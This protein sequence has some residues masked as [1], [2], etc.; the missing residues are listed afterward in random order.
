MSAPNPS[1]QTITL[2]RWPNE[3]QSPD[4]SGP[5]GHPVRTRLDDRSQLALWRKLSVAATET[6]THTGRAPWNCLRVTPP[7]HSNS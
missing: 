5:R 1:T 3:T 7:N 6:S 2:I 4:Y